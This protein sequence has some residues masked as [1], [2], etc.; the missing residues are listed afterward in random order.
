MNYDINVKRINLGGVNSFVISGNDGAILIDTG[1]YKDRKKL[2]KQIKDLDIKAIFLTHG[3]VDHIGGAKYISQKFNVP[4]AMSSGD[5]DLLSS[6]LVRRISA[7]TLFGK[8]VKIVSLNNFKKAHYEKFDID[9]FLADCMEFEYGNIRL[10]VIE[11][12]GHT[13]G[14]VGFIINNYFFVGDAI[15]NM[16]FPT[17]SLIFEDKEAALNS[18]RKIQNIGSNYIMS[19]HGNGFDIEKLKSERS[20]KMQ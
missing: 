15:M 20:K 9:I 18:F 6:N 4:I 5:L 12:P 10:K 1:Y 2:Y 14:S 13:K 16:F 3:H 19:G 17:I 8:I 11:L 7:K